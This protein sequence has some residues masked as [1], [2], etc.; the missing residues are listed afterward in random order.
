MFGSLTLTLN[1]KY[2]KYYEPKN[3]YF[4]KKANFNISS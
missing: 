4:K 1:L 2:L 3:N